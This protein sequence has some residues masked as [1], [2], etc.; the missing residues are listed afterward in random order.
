MSDGYGRSAPSPISRDQSVRLIV[1]TCLAEGVTDPRQIAYVLATAQHESQN[2]TSL[3]EEHGRKQAAQRGYEGNER[4]EGGAILGLGA[5]EYFGRG[6][7]HLTHWYN[8]Q[9][10][11][12]ALGR[13]DE[14][15]DNPSLA[16]EPEI[17]AGVLVVGMRDGLFTGRG[18]HHYITAENADHFNARRIVNGTDRASDI[19]ALARAWEPKV[20]DLVTSVRR[21]GV[22]LTPLPATR[23]DDAPL[24]RGDA[25]ARVFE[26][27]QYLAALNVADAAGRPLSPDG[28]FG[29]ATEQAVRHYQGR[30]GIEPRTGTVDQ[31][32]FDRIRGEA[33]QAEPGFRLKT[34]MEL[35][36]PL[37][38]GVLA[39]GE[40]GDA[41][42]DLQRQLQGLGARGENGQPLR[43]SR[44]YDAD[45][46][47]AVRGFQRDE[48]IAPA[49][50]LADERTRDALNARAVEFGLPETVEVVRRRPEVQNAHQQQAPAQEESTSS[51]QHRSMQQPQS[52]PF[53]DPFADRYFAAVMAG[54]SD[55]ADRIAIEFAQ[56]PEGQRLA[57][58][59]DEALA[60]Q[61]ALERQQ[62]LAGQQEPMMR[63]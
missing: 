18:L 33:L 48:G 35:H 8:Y 29:P 30:V 49:N 25:N 10:L 4:T 39:P 11:G 40:R 2:F 16:A 63:M 45:T 5:E 12:A 52:G 62:A 47:A 21:D 53:N 43:V 22:D 38:D 7:A 32:L 56:S 60:Q 51:E 28:D 24:R 50:G 44:R 34:I 15:L 17:A 13:G 20:A 36:G 41:V 42:A 1:Q 9:R 3:E 27:Q 57:R 54:D 59:G 46:Q 6:Y 14:L 19:A 55:L 31:V 23:D 58:L 61:Q 26:L 37:N